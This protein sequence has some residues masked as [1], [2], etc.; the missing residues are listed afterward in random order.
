MTKFNSFYPQALNML[1]SNTL[2]AMS[3]AQLETFLNDLAV[4]AVAD[5][6]FPKIPLTYTSADVNGVVEYTFDED[7]TQREINVL[8]AL[9][10]RLWIE[11]QLDDEGMFEV[12]YYDRD[13]KTF[14]KGNLINALEKRFESAKRDAKTAQRNYGRVNSDGDPGIGDVYDS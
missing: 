14:S 6:R 3:D 1:K 10:K 9:M 8:L 4:R 11:L 7:I 12:L 5:F 13:V 2:A